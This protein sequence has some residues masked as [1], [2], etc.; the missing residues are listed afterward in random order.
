MN[1]G[2]RVQDSSKQHM[3]LVQ[4]TKGG[5]FQNKRWKIKSIKKSFAAA[6]ASVAAHELEQN[7]GDE[8]HPQR[9]TSM[10]LPSFDSHVKSR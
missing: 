3:F 1:N 10:C 5:K 9:A 4:Q 7:A 8:Q 6:A 2:G